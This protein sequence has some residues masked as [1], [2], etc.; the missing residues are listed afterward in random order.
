MSEGAVPD[1]SEMTTAHVAESLFQRRTVVAKRVFLF[2]ATNLAILLMVSVVLAVLG[3]L[4]I[5]D[6][7]GGQGTLLASKIIGK[8]AMYAGGDVLIS[9]IHGMAQRGGVVT[10]TVRIGEVRSPLVGVGRADVI[11]SFEPAEAL[12]ALHK[13]SGDTVVITNIH[14]TIPFTVS[15][16]RMAYPD[17]MKELEK[18]RPSV[19]RLIE[20][21]ANEMAKEAG[22]AIT[23][24]T[25]MLGALAGSGVL[26]FSADF[27]RE[28]VKK[29]VPAKAVDINMVAFDMGMKVVEDQ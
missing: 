2:L 10:S 11:L 12:R 20:F 5:L 1:Y 18:I 9:E 17:V 22:A 7:A 6:R 4:G 27:L 25:V 19:K 15:L 24:N 16:G 3:S 23:A 26:P 21:D 28:A 8:A 14:P 29:S 13:A